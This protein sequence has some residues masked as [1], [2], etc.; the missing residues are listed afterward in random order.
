MIALVLGQYDFQSRD[1]SKLLEPCVI[2]EQ[3]EFHL[4]G[5]KQCL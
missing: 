3:S 4:Q 1:D 5:R 2:F